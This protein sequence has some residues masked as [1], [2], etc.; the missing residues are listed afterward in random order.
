M[1]AICKKTLLLMICALLLLSLCGCGEVTIGTKESGTKV[2]RDVTEFT[3]VLTAEQLPYLDKLTKLQ[4][5]DLSGSA[6]YD[7]ILAWAAAHPQ[8]G[9]RF[10]LPLP[11][12]GT[13]ENSASSLDLSTLRREQLPEAR[14]LMDRLVSLRSV[15]LGAFGRNDLTPADI[16]E[17][18]SAYPQIDFSYP[19]LLQGQPLQLDAVSLD[20]SRSDGAEIDTLLPWLP[21]MTQL[22]Y[23]ELGEGGDAALSRVSWDRVKAIRD[24]CPQASVG[25]RFTLYGRDMDLNETTLDF[26]HMTI[27]DQG[28]L[29]KAVAVCLPNLQLVDMDFCGVDDE[30]M[31]EIRDALP[32]AEVIWRIWFGNNYD[33]R[34]GGGYSVRTDVT[35]IVASNPDKAGELTPENTKSLKYLTKMKYLDLGHNSYLSSIDFVRYMPDLEVAIL[36]MGNWCD[37][38]P[39]A[40]CPKLEYAELQTTCLS[41]L[42]PLSGLTNLRH[43]NL[44]FNFALHDISPLYGLQLERLWIGCLDPVPPE[45]IET[46]RQLHPG[47]RVDVESTD[48]TQTYWRFTGMNEYGGMIAD[49]RYALLREQ[50][51]YDTAPLCYCYSENDPRYDPDHYAPFFY[52]PDW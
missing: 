35:R 10:T 34:T 40:S 23:I 6:C 50:F 7:E 3:G 43:L 13:V 46:F 33:T 39:L 51:E 27:G 32:N 21:Y 45:Q 52:Q 38:S 22:G 47:C 14:A 49:P 30:H 8:V 9:V 19:V 11:G 41:D 2:E 20:L 16:L 17:L 15:D 1:S 24:A 4:Y 29:I 26:N 44:C 18:R 5:A 12:G 31:E 42:R 28:A 37:A 25:Y 36:C 48:P